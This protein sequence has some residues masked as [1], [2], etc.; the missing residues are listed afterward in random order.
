MD[1]L[2]DNYLQ[3][4]IWRC[5]LEK[6]RKLSCLF[7]TLHNIE[8]TY[9][10]GRDD[11][12]EEDGVDLREDYKVP[13]CFDADIEEAFYAHWC[14]VLEMMVALSIRVDKEYIGDPAE[15]HP[16]AFFMEMIKNLGLDRM[17][18]GRYR[19][20]D[21]NHII[22][23]WL[24]RKFDRDGRGSPFPL[25]HNIRDQRKLEIWDQ[26]ISYIGENYD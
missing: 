18:N 24:D 23:R 16:E 1:E 22:Y 6:E 19:E 5:G 14:S 9:I 11:N 25:K 17:V 26:M 21:V 8:F 15:E 2:W 13:S 10:L 12:R 3:Y 20:E 7:E 4:L